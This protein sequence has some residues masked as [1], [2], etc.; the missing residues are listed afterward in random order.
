MTKYVLNSGGI[1]NAPNL[2]REFHRE[3]AKDLGESPKFLLCNFAQGRE[4]WETKFQGYSD[5]ISEDLPDTV[6]PSFALAMPDTFATQCCEADIIYFHGGDDHLI[7]YWMRQFDLV[8]LFKDK[9]VATNSA[10]SNLLVAHYWTCDWRQCGDGLGILPIKFIPH[11]NSA[12]GDDDPRG[13][14]DW[15]RAKRELEEY[16]DKSLPIY[17]LEEG[18]Y[19]VFEQ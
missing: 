3:L 9:V 12:F 8:E 11:Y 5:A 10:S 6:S 2:K 1:K 13:S 7:Q 18:E 19:K 4:Y 14:I 15:E 16:G 17:A